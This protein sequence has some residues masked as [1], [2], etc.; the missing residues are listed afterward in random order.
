MLKMRMFPVGVKTT[1]SN[2]MP[3]NCVVDGNNEKK[4]DQDGN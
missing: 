3:K 4:V 1:L 2:V